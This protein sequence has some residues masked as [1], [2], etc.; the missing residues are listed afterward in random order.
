MKNILVIYYSQSG[1]TKDI[2]DSIV[3]PIEKAD[4]INIDYE[5]IKPLK[6]YPFPWGGKFF[7]CFPESVK[8]IPCKLKPFSY[9]KDINYD[10]I[11]IAYQPWYLSPSIPVWSFLSSDETISLFTGK[12]VITIIGSRNMWICSQ[13][14]IARK[15][16][17]LNAKLIGNIVLADRS[18]N[19]IS[20]FNIIRWLI[21]GDKKPTLLLPEAGVSKKDIANATVFGEIVNDALKNN[22]WENLQKNLINKK[23]VIV[24][25]HILKMEKNAR[26]IFDKFAAYV[27]KKGQAND[28]E[29]TKRIGIFK[30]YL[31]FVIFVV[32]P[33]A[34]FIFTIVRLIFFRQTNKII[35]YYSGVDI[36]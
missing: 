32:S 36:K 16:R 30:V 24:K 7:S 10:L 31:L 26:K 15:L 5:L 13:E 17:E 11:L 19:Y 28:P 9:R 25:Y 12:K 18:S 8:G 1:Q 3:R 14:I 2:V 35:L 29:R 33:F 20:A 6:E 22:D 21:K 27:L 23:A 34:S 4:N